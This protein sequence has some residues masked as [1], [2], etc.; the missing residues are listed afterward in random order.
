[1]GNITGDLPGHANPNADDRCEC[2]TDGRDEGS[3][4][5]ILFFSEVEIQTHGHEMHII[6]CIEPECAATV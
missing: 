1:M 3:S 4:R 2:S 6:V 5:E